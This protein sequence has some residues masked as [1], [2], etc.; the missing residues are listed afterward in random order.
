[1]I[2]PSEIVILYFPKSASNGILIGS[3]IFQLPVPSTFA[4]LLLI[5]IF[6]GSAISAMIDLPGV[7]VPEISKMS[8]L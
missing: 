2:L 5:I 8:P 6:F 1:M 3:D 4:V 7:A